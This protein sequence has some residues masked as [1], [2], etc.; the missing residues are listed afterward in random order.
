MSPRW[1]WWLAF[2]FVLGVSD[3]PNA[4]AVLIASRGASYRRAMAFSFVAHAAGG[5]LAG[6][7]V[8]LTIPASCTSPRPTSRHLSGGR[9]RRSGVHAAAD[10]AGRS[11]QREHRAG[12]RAGRRRSRRGGLAGRRWGGLHG[13]HPYGVL[14]TLL[15]IVISPVLGGIRRRAAPPARRVLRRA[16]RD[17]DRIAAGVIWL[18]AGLVGLADGS[19]DGQKAMGLATA[20]WSPAGASGA[21]PCRSG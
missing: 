16:S 13:V 17:V 8:A 9:H 6:Q 4:S 18:T 11:G 15:A 5:L 3:A 2:A 7:A 21:S 12:R 14:G 1:P 19:N 20:C 10:P